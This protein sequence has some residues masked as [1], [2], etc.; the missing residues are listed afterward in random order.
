MAEPGDSGTLHYQSAVFKTDRIWR[1][2]PK[3]IVSRVKGNYKNTMLGQHI[4]M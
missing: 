3:V 2:V 1:S 4:L